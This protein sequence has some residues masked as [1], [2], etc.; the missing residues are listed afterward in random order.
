MDLNKIILSTCKKNELGEL[1][2][3]SHR[4]EYSKR[5][6]SQTSLSVE[7]LQTIQSVRN[8]GAYNVLLVNSR[9][10]EQSASFRRFGNPLVF[11]RHFKKQF[12]KEEHKIQ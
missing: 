6:N 12:R 3:N 9:R 11:R 2:R 7:K 5:Q 10:F 8:F 4:L 1:S